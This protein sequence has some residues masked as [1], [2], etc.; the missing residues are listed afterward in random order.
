MDCI[1]PFLFISSIILSKLWSIKSH[2][3]YK[4]M[5]PCNHHHNQD[6]RHFYHHNMYLYASSQL[7]FIYYPVFR[8][9]LSETLFLQSRFHFPRVF[10]KWSYIW[11]SFY[12][13]LVLFSIILLRSMHTVVYIHSFFFFFHYSI[14]FYYMDIP[15]FIY[16]LTYWWK[17]TSSFWLLGQKCVINICVQVCVYTRVFILLV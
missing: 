6:S 14:W 15:N 10:H 9:L 17:F 4:Y 1:F 8:Y 16:P 11:W 13:W 5:H 2:Y 7:V 12:V 3:F